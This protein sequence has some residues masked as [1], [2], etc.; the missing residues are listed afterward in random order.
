MNCPFKW[1]LRK[2]QSEPLEINSQVSDPCFMLYSPEFCSA[3][4]G[5]PGHI[6][7]ILDIE[8]GVGGGQGGKQEKIP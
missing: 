2:V 5:T 3:F 8:V 6:S 4:S 1:S 7:R